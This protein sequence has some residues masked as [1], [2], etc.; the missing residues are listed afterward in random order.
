MTRPSGSGRSDGPR[1]SPTDPAV[2]RT[3]GHH[4]ARPYDL[5][6]DRRRL[7]GGVQN[8][9]QNQRLGAPSTPTSGSGDTKVGVLSHQSWGA[10][11]P[12]RPSADTTGAVRDSQSGGRP[13]PTS[14]G[15][16]PRDRASGVHRPPPRR[17]I[18]PPPTPVPPSP[19][20]PS[21]ALR[22]PLLARSPRR[23]RSR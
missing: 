12:K 19:V 15:T 9:V 10:E 7:R 18:S 23:T 1:F 6:S 16:V 4:P 21:A 3:R 11:S 22:P 2:A 14:G 13:T 8:P 17:Q 5:Q 20:P